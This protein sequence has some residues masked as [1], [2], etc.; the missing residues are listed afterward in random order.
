M[1]F[2]PPY[3]GAISGFEI[4]P[5]LTSSVDSSHRFPPN[6]MFFAR[7][8]A[9]RISFSVYRGLVGL[10]K[11]KARGRLGWSRRRGSRSFPHSRRFP[12]RMLGR[13]LRQYP[14]SLNRAGVRYE[15]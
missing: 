14:G 13:A 3:A 1:E 10:C 12:F 15:W 9:R 5:L 11:A 8:M 4:H 2:Y 7:S 6:A